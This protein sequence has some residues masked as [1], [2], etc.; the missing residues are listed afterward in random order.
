MVGKLRSHEDK[1][2]AD[3]AKETVR[4]W[5]N[6]VS[7]QKKPDGASASGKA[8]VRPSATTTTAKNGAVASTATNHL[9]MNG[10][11]KDGGLSENNKK[12]RDATSDG[13]SK[14]QTNDKTRDGSIILLYNAIVLDSS[15]CNFPP[16]F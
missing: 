5:K 1:K 9:G 10:T 3:I 6:D 16:A 13:I 8:D 7:E 14:V 15:E 11:A 4:K 2:V 12:P